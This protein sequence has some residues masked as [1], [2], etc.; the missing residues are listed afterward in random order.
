MWDYSSVN[1][2]WEKRVEKLDKRVYNFLRQEIED[3]RFYSKCLD[4]ISYIPVPELDNLYDVMNYKTNETYKINSEYSS[5]FSD[6]DITGGI[7]IGSGDL[8]DVG[9]HYRYN[10]EYGYTMKNLF[11][12]KRLIDD[13]TNYLTVDIATTDSIS[14][15]KKPLVIDGVTVKEGHRVLVKNNI[16]NSTISSDIDPEEYFSHNYYF[17]KEIGNNSTYFYFNSEN[18]I[19]RIIDGYLV[20]TTD[21]DTYLTNIRYSVHVIMGTNTHIQ[22]HLSR[23]KSGNFPLVSNNDPIEFNIK[24]NHIV[25]N[26]LEYRNTLDNEFYCGIVQNKESVNILGKTYQIPERFI[27]VGDFG[28]IINYQDDY[29]NVIKNKF[30]EDLKDIVALSDKYLTIGDNGTLLSLNKLSLDPIFIEMDSFETFNSINFIDDFRGL[31]V[32]NNGL[33]LSTRDQ[34]TWQQIDVDIDNDLNKVNFVDLSRAIIVGDNGI[35]KGL[36]LNN[37]KNTLED[38]ELKTKSTLFNEKRVLEDLTDIDN[39]KIEKKSFLYDGTD[40]VDIEKSI[41]GSDF[42]FDFRFKP[43]DIG[44]ASSTL[45]SFLTEKYPTTSGT[46]IDIGVRI[47]VEPD[48]NNVQRVNMYVNRGSNSDQLVSLVGN[49]N[50]ENDVWYHVLV[51]RDKGV[52]KLF[53]N[54]TLSDS[55]DDGFGGNFGNFNT[56]IRLGAELTYNDSTLTY[57][58]TSFNHFIGVIDQVRFFDKNLDDGEVV[59]FSNNYLSDLDGLVAWYKFNTHK[60]NNTTVQIRTFDLILETPLILPSGSNLTAYNNDNM[61]LDGLDT[62]SFTGIITSG[63]NLISIILDIAIDYS[64]Q[65]MNNQLFIETDTSNIKNIVYNDND[66]CFYGMGDS[67]FRIDSSNIDVDLFN[68]INV[69]DIKDDVI[70][71][72][73]YNNIVLDSVDQK[74][75][76]ISGSLNQIESMDISSICDLE[77][78]DPLENCNG[79]YVTISMIGSLNSLTIENSYKNDITDTENINSVN[80]IKVLGYDGLELQ[81]VLQI[82]ITYMGS[83]LPRYKEM[84][85]AFTISD[86]TNGY[87]EFSLDD[88]NFTPIISNGDYLIP[89][90]VGSSV[91]TIRAVLNP[92]NPIGDRVKGFIKNILLYEAD[93][94]QLEPLKYYTGGLN[95]AKLYFSQFDTQSQLAKI[96]NN[97]LFSY[98]ALKSIKIDGNEKFNIGTYTTEGFPKYLYPTDYVTQA[99]VTCGIGGLCDYISYLPNNVMDR[100]RYGFG[101]TVSVHNYQYLGN[102]FGLLEAMTVNTIQ[103]FGIDEASVSNTITDIDSPYHIGIDLTKSFRMEVDSLILNHDDQMFYDLD[104]NPG[105]SAS[106]KIEVGVGTYSVGTADSPYFNQITFTASTGLEWELKVKPFNPDQEYYVEMEL[107]GDITI[108]IVSSSETF[109][110]SGTGSLIQET[111]KMG[112]TYSFNTNINELVISNDSII[113]NIN[114]F[115]ITD[116]IATKNIIEWK[117]DTCEMSYKM[118]GVEEDGTGFLQSGGSG[119]Y[120]PT[121]TVELTCDNADSLEPIVDEVYWDKFKSKMLF[122][123]YDIASK[124][125]FFDTNT[126]EYQLPQPIVIS[127]I[128]ILKLDSIVGQKSWLDYSQDSTKDFGY[129][130]NKNDS[131]TI[132]YSSTFTKTTSSS[133]YDVILNTL[134]T[135]D[136]ADINGATQGLLPNFDSGTVSLGVSTVSATYSYFFYENYMIIQKPLSYVV[137]L[138]DIIRI[139]NGLVTDNLMVVYLLEDGVDKY[140]YLKTTF[141]QSITN[142]LKSWVKTTTI[143]NLNNF[144]NLVELVDNFNVH[145]ISIGYTLKDNS[146]GTLVVD[147]NFNFKTSYYNLQCRV[148][149]TNAILNTVRQNMEYVSKVLTFGYSAR[150]NILDYLS[151]NPVF[152]SNYRLSILPSYSF[153][154]NNLGVLY[155]VS[156]GLISFNKSLKSEWESIPKYVFLDLTFGSNVLSCLTTKKYYDSTSDRYIIET[157]NYYGHIYDQSGLGTSNWSLRVRNTLGEVSE[158]LEKMN[159]IQKSTSLSY[160]I[161][162]LSNN[163]YTSYETLKSELNFKPDVDSY[164]KALLN[165]KEIKEYLSGIVYTDYKNELA[166]NIINVPECSTYVITGVSK[167][168]SDCVGCSYS[169]YVLFENPSNMIS[170][171]QYA[172]LGDV[173]LYTYYTNRVPA[174]AYGFF[175]NILI[176]GATGSTTVDIPIDFV[177]E[178]GTEK[179]LE[180]I[181]E[182]L[183]EANIEI[184]KNSIVINTISYTP[185]E[186]ERTK[187]LFTDNGVS[188]LIIRVNYTAGINNIDLRNIRVGSDVCISDCYITKLHVVSHE[189]SVGDGIVVDIEDYIYNL[190]NLYDSKFNENPMSGWVKN[191]SGVT[192]SVVIT[193]EIIDLDITAPTNVYLADSFTVSIGETYRVT[194]DYQMTSVSGTPSISPSFGTDPLNLDND[195]EILYSTDGYYHVVSNFIP[196]SDVIYIGFN[197]VGNSNVKLSTISLDKIE[198]VGEYY[199]GYRVVQGII[200]DTEIVIN[201][202]YNGTIEELSATFSYINR[203]GGTVI[204]TK[205]ISNLGTIEKCTFDP[206]LNYSPIDIFELGKD[207]KIKQAVEIKPN[208]WIENSD[209]TVSISDRIDMNNYRFRLIDDL[210]IVDLN[211]KYPWILESEIRNALIGK[212]DNGLVWYSGIWDCGRWFGG[213]WYSGEWRNGEWYNGIWNNSN[214]QDN[215]IRAEVKVL[216]SEMLRSIWHN[217]NFRDGTWNGGKFRKGNYYNGTWNKGTWDG[218]TWHTGTWNNGSFKRGTWVD[219]TWN[220]GKFNCDLGMSSWLDG[221]WNDGLFECG[222][223]Y[224]GRFNSTTVL[225][226]FGRGS[227]LSRPAIWE[228]GQFING[229]FGIDNTRH[230]HSIWKTGY[231]NNGIWYNGTAHQITWNNGKWIDGVVKDIDVSA[232]YGDIN[233]VYFFTLKGDWKF[234]KGDILWIIDNNQYSSVYGTDSNHGQYKVDQDYISIN[235][236]EYTK[237]LVIKVPSSVLT[238]I[239]DNGG[240]Y[241]EG[242]LNN[243]IPTDDTIDSNKI[244][245]VVSHFSKTEWSNGQFKNGIFDGIFF[246]NGILEKGVFKSGNFG[247]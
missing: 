23:L 215:I 165:Q 29:S 140:I 49:I 83:P 161:T 35:V 197:M 200:N 45:F 93:C 172:I 125:Y 42:T 40:W 109:T 91:F 99:S 243:D 7:P 71:D 208:D 53:I 76:L 210:S 126:G 180:F 206:Y 175:N 58:S 15:T 153:S 222:T 95:V 242:Y 119:K 120:T 135:N 43:T 223:W 123:N 231:W 70:L 217:G 3:V 73:P 85:C 4:G 139:E 129:L 68:Q 94:V 105:S 209:N 37:N 79:A 64:N 185:S 201:T 11:T 65:P 141:N 237:V 157:Y 183:T 112:S 28:V 148:S 103:T 238:L 63:G 13:S 159:N 228:S 122:I 239:N 69:L 241:A 97:E 219:G 38:I 138:G 226:E 124:L 202:A 174:L 100:I 51:T 33:I 67:L 96:N 60:P 152:S 18:G 216:D 78:H 149:T 84:F 212:D 17:V 50:I 240:I 1:D 156:D 131:N 80:Y 225:S 244:T 247:Y 163:T 213:T 72:A 77:I 189:L 121:C 199:D 230:D 236:G 195:F 181:I 143:T 158:D 198:D 235:S 147:P 19:Y 193:T 169:D 205:L 170:Y 47:I 54:Q 36:T 9:S 133:S 128:S 196:T 2:N 145:P 160:H 86:I 12:P 118:S 204:G 66:G 108:E 136:I 92:I 151:N 234:R 114:N 57:S 102:S 176:V 31:I 39:L 164:A 233:G 14:L 142:R 87:F 207:D 116:R 154:N 20:R 22:Q 16:T 187:T 44:T 34:Y 130:G 203:C 21:L 8:S 81:S 178:N 74:L 56:R 101:L 186:T 62:E 41:G 214:V 111:I 107:D 75:F 59:V 137:S 98:I 89:L 30:K 46:T 134:T 184:V 32:G 167:Y 218:G 55:T 146:G 194:F 229:K 10:E 191:I 104:N 6:T 26:S 25:R 224:N 182:D 88:I 90:S 190:E 245:T 188:D 246:E 48:V 173:A 155:T 150:Y 113:V 24:E 117:P 168:S 52:Y 61:N 82:P 171:N 27:S 211:N 179:V 115:V 177:V 221:V 106:Y 110:F 232:F 132:K 127:D 192:S 227:S 5:N 162:D 166:V 144:R 220:G